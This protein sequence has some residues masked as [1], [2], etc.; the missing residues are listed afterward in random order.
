MYVFHIPSFIENKEKQNSR[1][2]TL[3][4]ECEQNNDPLGPRT[5]LWTSPWTGTLRELTI[6]NENEAYCNHINSKRDSDKFWHQF[7][8]FCHEEGILGS[9]EADCLPGY[10]QLAHGLS[11]PPF[12]IDTDSFALH[13]RWGEDNLPR[14][15]VGM[16]PSGTKK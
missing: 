6:K 12:N 8:L 5:I 7:S 1:I 10:I 2:L 11:G 15:W 3:K 13:A 9:F 14:F 16:C 4:I